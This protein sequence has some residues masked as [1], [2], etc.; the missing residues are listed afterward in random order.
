MGR[1]QVPG[2]L[3]GWTLAGSS[4]LW[5]RTHKSLF[6]SLERR[7]KNLAAERHIQSDIVFHIS[8]CFAWKGDGTYLYTAADCISMFVFARLHSD[9]W[10]CQ[11]IQ[12]S[13]AK[14]LLSWFSLIYFAYFPKYFKLLFRS[15]K[16]F[17][18]LKLNYFHQWRFGCNI[19]HQVAQRHT[20]PAQDLNLNPNWAPRC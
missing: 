2:G 5:Q 6:L 4:N 9:V 12:S 1:R 16:T 11:R 3:A 18:N 20:S 7:K 8:S 15:P 17:I 13:N 10:G 19:Y 14:Y